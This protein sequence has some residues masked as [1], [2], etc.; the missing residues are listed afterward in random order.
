MVRVSK[1]PEIR[2]KEFI[3]AATELFIEK[4]FDETSITDITN[5]VDLSH[6]S[7]FYYFK[8]KNEIMKAV[9]YDG[10]TQTRQL[11]KHLVENNELN[12]LE[13]FQML[14][15]WTAETNTI[16]EKLVDFC[17]RDSNVVLHRE[18]NLRSRELIIPLFT[19]IV[20]QG[21]RENTINVEYPKETVEYIY[22]VF[23]NIADSLNTTKNEEEYHKKIYALNIL[24]KKAFGIKGKI[25]LLNNYLKH[26]LKFE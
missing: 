1:D 13:K 12:A 10:L 7:F 16:Y 14:F 2:R 22:Y 15:K 4:G 21:I 18:Y 5:R 17:H 9:I 20:E 23:E 24:I 25:N 6:G 11:V 8:S 26:N 3:D 19:K